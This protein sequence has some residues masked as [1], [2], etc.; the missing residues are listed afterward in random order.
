MLRHLT[1]Q[2]YALIEKINIDFPQGLS[3]ITG[4]T[5]AGKSILLGALSLIAGNRA[6]TSA[7]SDKTKKCIVEAE[8]LIKD[9]QLNDYF[10]FHE[11]DYGEQTVIRR[12]IS[13]EG[14]SRAFIND[15]PVTLG[16]LKEL[17]FRLI[18][19]HS[20][21]ETLALNESEY[22]ISVVD[23]YANMLK[24]V[25]TYSVDFKRY[26]NLERTLSELVE[27]EKKYKL[28]SDYWRFQFEELQELDIQPGE[29]E[30]I[31]NELKLVA[32]AEEIKTIFSKSN[33][34]INEGD[35]N[36]LSSLSEFKSLVAGISTLSP[37]YDELF[38]RINSVQIEMKDIA[39]EITTLEEKVNFNPEKHDKLSSRIDLI[40]RLEKKHHVN[41]SD[42]LM[43]VQSKIEDQ[44]NEI[45][46]LETEILTRTKS[47]EKFRKEVYALAKKIST[48][49][50]NSFPKLEKEIGSLLTSL[51]MPNA[52]LKVEHVLLDELSENGIDKICFLFSA[53]KGSD[54]KEVSK[55]ASGGEMSRLMLSIKSLIA[56]NTFL[57]TIIFDEIDTGV[58]GGVAEKVGQMIY[59]M[60][61]SMQVLVI[62]HLPQIA[63][64]GISHFVVYKE[65]KG[66][67]TFTGIKT[68]S[69]DDRILEIAKILSADK[70]T[71]A[72]ILNAKELLRFSK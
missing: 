42:E 29:Q 51:A 72:S 64:K 45:S 19:I 41:S 1:I 38:K 11:L 32:K 54:I 20:Q 68:L 39:V 46:S 10:A 33:S 49:R 22:Q 15:T 60:S 52:K 71:E 62:T 50:V 6:D 7:L 12:E 57:P 37:E 2:N 13:P 14:K 40:Y 63:S 9:Y 44:L 59:E 18:D 16:Q 48:N 4:E 70:P 65:E 23:A 5:G 8:F 34:L 27:K 21:H 24:D 36:L 58:S 61:N 67:N 30:L 47:L 53:N 66:G 26:K 17:G 25:S 69:K 56:K 3:V 28:D 55:V 35:V 43:V 31:E